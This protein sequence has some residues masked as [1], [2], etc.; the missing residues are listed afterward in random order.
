MSDYTKAKAFLKKINDLKIK[1]VSKVKYIGLKKDAMLEKFME[2][3]EAVDDAGKLDSLPEDLIEFYE[4]MVDEAEEETEEAEEVDE[5]E[6]EEDEWED[7]EDEVED[8]DEIEE[9]EDLDE[10]EVEDEDEDPDFDEMNK[11]E[12]LA[13]AK[14]NDISVK[15]ALKKSI[16]KLRAFLEEQFDDM[17]DAEEEPEPAPKTPKKKPAKKPAKKKAPKRKP[18]AD[19]EDEAEEKPKRARTVKATK[20]MSA[21]ITNGVLSLQYGDSKPRKLK[22]Q[23]TDKNKLKA[24]IKKAVTWAK[25]QGATPGQIQAVKKAFTS[26]GYHVTR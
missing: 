2:T 12:C 10:D 13:W 14:E 8:E 21:R 25:D 3:V 23:N 18:A 5:D 19:D 4:G 26:N 22:V 16:K 1:G 6:A 9:E 20:R 17:L 15:P 11:A 7:V 24:T